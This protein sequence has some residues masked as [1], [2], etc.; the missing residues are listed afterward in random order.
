MVRTRS[1]VS[2]VMNERGVRSHEF[3]RSV[4]GTVCGRID[5]GLA[6]A[7]RG[8][9]IGVHSHLISELAGFWA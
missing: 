7:Y 4:D 3:E 1:R 8:G 2:S 6:R 5:D 9:S